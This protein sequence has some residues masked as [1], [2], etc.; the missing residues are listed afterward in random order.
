MKALTSLLLGLCLAAIGGVQAAT[1]EVFKRAN[2]DAPPDLIIS[3]VA[4]VARFAPFLQTFAEREGLVV[5][6]TERMSNELV[7][8]TFDADADTDDEI[9]SPDLILSSAMEQQLKLVNDGYAQPY[10]SDVIRELPEWAQWRDELFAYAF[11]PIVMVIN[12][13]LLA[14][15]ELPQSRDQL[16]QLIRA[17]GPL[18][19]GKI[20]MTDIETVGLGY[21]TWAHDSRQS[22]TY[23]QLL[24]TFGN[25]HL[26]LYPDS[27]S[28]LQALL[29]GEIFIAYNLVGSY[30]FD[31][32][33]RYPWITTVMPADYTSVLMR[34]ALIPKSAQHP[35]AARRFLDDLLST[36]GQA[37]LGEQTG[38]IPVISEAG[39]SDTFAF[40]REK[41]HGIFRPIPLSLQLLLQTDAEKRRLLLN[42]WRAAVYPQ[43]K[44]AT[45]SAP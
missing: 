25:A 27:E 2:V 34:T 40:L 7:P 38:L 20:G 43:Q 31:F 14:G 15:A 4:P 41:S 45:D 9:P 12:R 8:V 22:R 10:R 1:T 24:E 13:D 33:N 29:K 21:L 19:D 44:P 11:E 3:G 30:A 16:L 28:V 37:R 6:Y 26:R 35:E 42:E 36:S 32:S 18:V 17:K 23:G 5:S 39:S